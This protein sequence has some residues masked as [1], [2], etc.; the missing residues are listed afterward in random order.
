MSEQNNE[1]NNESQNEN[2]PIKRRSEIKRA[3][4]IRKKSEDQRT[5][6]ERDWLKKYEATLMRGP[7][8]DDN[9]SPSDET[10]EDVQGADETPD[11]GPPPPPP[12]VESSTRNDD[13]ADGKP[14][15]NWRKKYS[16]GT[17]DVGREKTV[18]AIASQWLAA[19]KFCNDQIRM[20][21]GMPMFDEQELFPH[22]VVTVDDALPQK[23][24]LKSSHIAAVGTTV[25]IGQRI[26]RHRKIVET[27]EQNAR[28]ADTVQPPREPL[29]SEQS[30]KPEES[31]PQEP[32]PRVDETPKPVEPLIKI[33]TE[34]GTDFVPLPSDVF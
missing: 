33:P 34:V 8:A 5:E 31:K 23:V 20:S 12:R 15:T 27:Y 7:R 32:T 25:I 6:A 19:L 24:V 2:Q 30:P 4:R 10:G 14:D 16:K 11:I 29:P 18:V 21:G 28:S 9:D 1:Q 26:A 3:W 22:L 13:E 17:K